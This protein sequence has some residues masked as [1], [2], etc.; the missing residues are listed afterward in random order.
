[1][2]VYI[3]GVGWFKKM[4]F[5][6]E[7]SFFEC[8]WQPAVGGWVRLCKVCTVLVATWL[9]KARKSERIRERVKQNGE[10]K[11]RPGVCAE[12]WFHLALSAWSCLV[13][14]C[15]AVEG[16]FARQLKQELASDLKVFSDSSARKRNPFRSDW[17]WL[18]RDHRL[19][20]ALFCLRVLYVCVNINERMWLHFNRTIYI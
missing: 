18:T 3:L 7:S 19:S 14:S 15:S 17:M 2:L 5:S 1:M 9:G 20:S 12:D 13:L 8:V 11:L 4:Y 16:F 6:K 10:Q